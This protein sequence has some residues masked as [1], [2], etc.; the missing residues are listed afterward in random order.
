MAR[1]DRIARIDPPARENAF[2]GWLTLRDLEGREREPEL[3]RRARLRYLALRPVRRLLERGL[4]A[5]DPA[6]FQHQLDSV[7]EELGQLPS[8]DP[9]RQILADYLKQVGGRAPRGVVQAT[10]DVGAAAEAS[11][12]TYAAEEFYRTGLEL[13]Q[14]H[15][16]DGLHVQALRAIGRI[17]RRRGEWDEAVGLLE[18]AATLAEEQDDLVEWARALDGIA[19]ARLQAGDRDAARS[20]LDDIAAR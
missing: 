20:T 1:Y 18:R 4:D 5:L 3:G 11:G 19:A 17:H 13:T 16:L 6:S 12:H 8:R 14:R 2:G 15:G 9:E 7:R 10:L